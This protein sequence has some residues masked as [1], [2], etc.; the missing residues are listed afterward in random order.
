VTP[1]GDAALT[2]SHQPVV[3]LTQVVGAQIAGCPNNTSNSSACLHALAADAGVSGALTV[4]RRAVV[5]DQLSALTDGTPTGFRVSATAQ[6][7]VLST[8]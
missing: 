2:V 5:T 7:A 8:G 6:Q 3:V 4:N 1:S